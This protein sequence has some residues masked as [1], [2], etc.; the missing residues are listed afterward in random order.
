M[1]DRAAGETDRPTAAVRG[2]HARQIVRKYTGDGNSTAHQLHWTPPGKS[3][4]RILGE[5]T[6]YV[7]RHRPYSGPMSLK[8]FMLRKALSLEKMELN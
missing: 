4:M 3:R 5:R 6:Q 8:R 1:P 7:H 2:P